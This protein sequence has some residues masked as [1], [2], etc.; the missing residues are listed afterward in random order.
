MTE[1]TDQPQPDSDERAAEEG[2]Q[3]P[4]YDDGHTID[5]GEVEVGEPD[6]RADE[7]AK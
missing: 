3:D 7:P 2:R 4:T 6:V 5:V 1:S